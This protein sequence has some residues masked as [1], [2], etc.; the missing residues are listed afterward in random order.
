[1]RTKDRVDGGPRQHGRRLGAVGGRAASL[2]GGPSGALVPCT[3]CAEVARLHTLRVVG[4][5]KL[6]ANTVEAPRA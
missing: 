2:D 6:G 3:H 1:M 5:Q 4:W